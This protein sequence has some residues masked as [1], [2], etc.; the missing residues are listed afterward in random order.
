MIS[1]VPYTGDPVSVPATIS[2]IA[3]AP[4]Q[5]QMVL[6]TGQTGSG[7]S[8]YARNYLANKTRVL[9]ADADFREYGALDFT[10]SG[11]DSLL[12]YLQAHKS[13]FRVSYTP[14]P[15]E[16][17]LMCDAARVVGDVTFV[18]EECDRFPDP[19]TCI[20]YDEIVSRGRHWGVSI[21]A[22]SRFPAAIPID[23]RREANQI[24][25]FRHHEPADIEWY[26]KVI[27]KT[28]EQLPTLGLHEFILW[29]REKGVFPR[30]KLDLK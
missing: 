8:T 23:L 10:Q 7:K 9:I 24:I 19:R 27:G 26:S 21:L 15:W 1:T 16:Y 12:D 20:E 11:F 25:A 30:R 3:G 14:R 17:D 13:F 5:R 28:A 18:I 22:V 2:T 6:I 29:D 4:S